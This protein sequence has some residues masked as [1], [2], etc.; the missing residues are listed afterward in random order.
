MS[1]VSEIHIKRL[2][3]IMRFELRSSISF[4]HPTTSWTSSRTR[5]SLTN[6]SMDSTQSSQNS[7][8]P[9]ANRFANEGQRK[10]RERERVVTADLQKGKREGRLIYKLGLVD[11]NKY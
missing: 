3:K 11:L 8:P 6:P 4:D 10:E 2:R 1:I 5:P 7:R 9:N